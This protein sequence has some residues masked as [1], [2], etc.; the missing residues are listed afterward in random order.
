M[1]IVYNYIEN[2][3]LKVVDGF[4]FVSESDGICLVEIKVDS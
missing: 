2:Y 1:Y 4:E 3:F